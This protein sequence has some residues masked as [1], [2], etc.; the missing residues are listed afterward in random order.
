MVVMEAAVAAMVLSVV[1][2]LSIKHGEALELTM[3]V[4][5]AALAILPHQT[6]PL[7]T[8]VQEQFA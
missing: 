1:L 6:A 7:V 4:V 2:V 5:V 3:A 8:V